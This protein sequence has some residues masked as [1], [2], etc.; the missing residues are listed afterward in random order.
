MLNGSTY[1]NLIK[2]FLVRAEIY[3]VHAARMEEHEKVLID[4]TLEGKTREE[5]GLRP[6]TCTEI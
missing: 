5:L 6:F 4:P 1:E 3:D 2:Y